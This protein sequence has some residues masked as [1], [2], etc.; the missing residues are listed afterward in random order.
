[1]GNGAWNIRAKCAGILV[2]ICLSEIMER[3]G[4]KTYDIIWMHSV[5]QRYSH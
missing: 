1:M 4:V 5:K 2:L 3:P